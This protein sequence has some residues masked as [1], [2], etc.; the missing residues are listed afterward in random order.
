MILK[1]L[2]NKTKILTASYLGNKVFSDPAV[3][4]FIINLNR[5]DQLFNKGIDYQGSPLPLYKPDSKKVAAAMRPSATFNEILA[6][7]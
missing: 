5:K 2:L 6:R 7:V 3:K 1:D 4:E